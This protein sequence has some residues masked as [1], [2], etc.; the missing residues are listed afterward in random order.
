MTIEAIPPRISGAIPRQVWVLGFVSLLMDVSSEIVQTL[1]PLYLVAGLGAS[2]V[3]VGFVEG[4]SIAVAMV[5]RLSSGFLSD[6][7]G[8][9]KFLA[10]LGYG[11]AAISKP[12]FPL[13]DSLFWIVGA[14]FLDRVG[15]GIRAAPRDALIADITPAEIRGASFGLR[16][17]LDTVGGFVGPI[18]A[19]GLML[20]TGG[21]FSTIFWIAVIPAFLAVGLLVACVKEPDVPAARKKGAALNL[22][23]AV[24]LNRANWVVILVSSI[25]AIARFSEAFLLLRSQ[26]YRP[27]RYARH[28][29]VVSFGGRSRPRLYRDYP[30][31]YSGHRIVGAAYGL[32]ARDPCHTHSRYCAFPFARHRFRCFQFDHRHSGACR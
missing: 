25:L 16:K 2:A 17:S 1:L 28:Q 8:N 9:R 3:T 27:Q 30:V 21:S 31:P 12:L 26:P 20:W 6:W 10:A 24:L 5:T 29:P 23:D 13:A 22:K 32:F 19:I 11:L 18:A 14:K 7:F 4:F 15:K